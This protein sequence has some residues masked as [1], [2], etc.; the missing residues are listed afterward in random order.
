MDYKAA[1]F[2]VQFLPNS[3]IDR[4]IHAPVTFHAHP[5]MA[6]RVL[7]PGLCLPRLLVRKCCKY[8]VLVARGRATDSVRRRTNRETG[9]G[10]GSPRSS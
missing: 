8:A 7:A 2:F 3:L 9:L 6:R 5:P 10:H 1:L 4:G